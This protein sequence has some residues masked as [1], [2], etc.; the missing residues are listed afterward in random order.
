MFNWIIGDV[1]IFKYPEANDSDMT[2][3][4]EYVI[5]RCYDTIT[6][7]CIDICCD[8]GHTQTKFKRKFVHKRID[9]FEKDMKDII[10]ED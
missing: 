9:M 3:H 10:N 7:D 8:G 6:N 4:K 5:E 1:V 2:I